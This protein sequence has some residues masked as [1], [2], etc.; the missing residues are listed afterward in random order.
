MSNR[1]RR[2]RGEASIFQRSDGQW[3]GSISLGYHES[4]KRKRRTVY[5]AT[6]GEVREKIDQLKT[7]VKAGVLPDGSAITIG[8][9][10]D[11]WLQTKKASLGVRTFEER[12]AVIDN[13]LRPRIGGM[14]LSKLNSLHIDGLYADLANDRVGAPTIRGA[15][16]VLGT[17]LNYAVKRKLIV[18]NPAAAVAKPKV[19]DREMASLDD[20]QARAV[21]LAAVDSNVFAILTTAL[22]TGM[23][24]GELL[25]LRWDDIDLRKGT[26]F[27]R[28]SLA[29]T[30]D[31]Q[32]HVKETKT[33]ASRRV[34]T[35]PANAI[36][37][38]TRHKATAMKAGLLAAPVF[39]TRNGNFLNKTNVL[40]AFRGVVTKANKS[41]GSAAENAAVARLIPE[42]IR[43]HDL[44]HT[45]ASLLLSKGCSLKAV[46]A[47]LGHSNPSLTLRVYAHCLPNDDLQ[48]TGELNKMFA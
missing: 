31:R 37:A 30:R 29:Q 40:R 15:A 41:I 16:N 17:V 4:G 44:R 3:V 6:K 13:H 39:C 10:L 27:V 25:A 48:L 11:R 42:T 12:Q 24:Q 38:L 23:R 9:L 2:G 33:K 21:L 26:I 45:C 19:T 1:K 32:F 36:D 14:K 7:D 43:F 20:E 5:G 35:L 34:I 46:S 28:V 18:H 22:G 8:Q 47:R